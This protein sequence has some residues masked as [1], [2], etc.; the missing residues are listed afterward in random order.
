MADPAPTNP[1]ANP[2]DPPDPDAEAART[3][4][5]GLIKE[6]LLEVIAER[7]A[8]PP[9]GKKVDVLGLLFG[10]GS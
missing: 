6:V 10:S 7:E 5:K 3:Q 9:K 4:A 1:P 8:A 2:P